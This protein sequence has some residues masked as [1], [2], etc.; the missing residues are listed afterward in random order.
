MPYG[1]YVDFVLNMLNARRN[2]LIIYLFLFIYF[3]ALSLCGYV[4]TFSSCGEWGLSSSCS[5]WDSYFSGFFYCRAQTLGAWASVVAACKLISHGLQALEGA[6]FSSCG[7][8]AYLLCSMWNLP[9]PGIE[10]VSPALAGR[11]FTTALGSGILY[12]QPR[13]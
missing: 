9:S 8:Q 4:R 7:S 5:A 3:I 13:Y 10:P 1:S 12:H 2:F 11:F 6:G